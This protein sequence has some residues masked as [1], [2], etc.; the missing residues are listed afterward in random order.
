MIIFPHE[1]LKH[2]LFHPRHDWVEVLALLE[3]RRV[4][5]FALIHLGP[6]IRVMIVLML[7]IF[8]VKFSHDMYNIITQ[9]LS[10]SEAILLRNLCIGQTISSIYFS[11]QIG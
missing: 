1:L 7:Q 2:L 8:I 3:Q 11:R 5:D 6:K 9:F 10:S 4:R